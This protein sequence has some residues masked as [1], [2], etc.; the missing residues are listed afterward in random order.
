V[1]GFGTAQTSGS[2]RALSRALIGV[3]AVLLLVS[4]SPGALADTKKDLDKARKELTALVDKINEEQKQLDALAE[5]LHERQADLNEQAVAIDAA[6]SEYGILEGKVMAI[7]QAY[8]DARAH[9]RRVRTQLNARARLAYEQGP[10]GDLSFLLGSSSLADLSDRV[11]FMGRL[12]QSDASLA[13]EVHNQANALDARRGDLEDLLG[14]QRD[15]LEELDNVRK[16]LDAKFNNQQ[17]LVDQQNELLASLESDKARA[18]ELV[19][20]LKKKRDAEL[21]AAARAATHGGAIIDNLPGPLYVCPVDNP[22]AY[23]DSFGAPRN[24]GG[25]H[26]HAGNDILAPLGTIIR[27]PFD[28]VVELDPNGLGGNAI[29][30]HGADGWIYGAHLSQYGATGQV[31]KGEIIGYVG[32][33][34]DAQGGPYHLHF[35][36]HPDQLPSN[37]YRSIYGYTVINGDAVDPYPYLNE[38]C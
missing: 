37:P 5:Q 23:G 36:W 21:R 12:A 3:L 28:G 20:K 18:T 19:A 31:S 2:A 33:T 27:A 13:A 26:P 35:E 10:A 24:A 29:I 15:K 7:R 34:G 16:V 32:N 25:Y 17:Q 22:K 38:I 9:Y 4:V 11:E 8:D 30:E 6:E 14:Q 1:K